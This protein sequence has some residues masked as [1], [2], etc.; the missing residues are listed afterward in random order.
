VLIEGNVF[1]NSWVA[2][3]LGMAIVIK[4][5]TETCGACTW[6]GTKDV[7]VRWNV[8]RNA[9]RGLNVQAIDGSSAGTTASHTERVTVEQNLFTG[10]GTSNGIVP[11]DGWL[12]L[13]THDLKDVSVSH[14]TFVSNTPGYGLA[15]YFTYAAGGARRI[16][17]SDN[18]F[19]GLSYYGFGSDGGLHAAA[20]TALAGSSWSFQRNVVAQVDGQF[21]GA[22]PSTSWYVP[23]VARHRARAGLR[24]WS[25]RRRS[26]G[27]PR[28]HG[29]G[30]RHRRAHAA[31]G[32]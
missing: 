30:R 24:D 9:H 16:G 4:S 14:N 27:R 11:S 15:G 12:M 3:Q 29:S 23:A 26:R 2:A 20:F 21:V 32:N 28:R 13:L 10:I 8:F 18:V 19:A 6:E 5:S 1:E 31:H 17:I 7:T 22:N 25:R